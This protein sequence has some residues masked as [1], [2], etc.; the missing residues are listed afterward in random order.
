MIG[1]RILP[2]RLAGTASDR[3]IGVVYEQSPLGFA[4]DH[5]EAFVQ[6]DPRQ[7]RVI[8]GAWPSEYERPVYFLEL[9]DNRY[10]LGWCE[11]E[12][13][14]LLLVPSPKSPVP[15]RHLRYPQEA[16]IVGRVIG[17]A[18]RIAQ[19]GPDPAVVASRGRSSP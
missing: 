4:V 19:G 2:Q 3:L 7:N 14:H 13:N 10:A 6:I 5:P 16:E 11:L 12:G 8:K 18:H 9:R 1:R 15:I 17:F